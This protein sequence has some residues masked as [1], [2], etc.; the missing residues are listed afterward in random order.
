MAREQ[1][2]RRE[3]KA[4]HYVG[5]ISLRENRDGG[6][7]RTLDLSCA[8]AV[9]ADTLRLATDV[10]AAAFAAEPAVAA[11]FDVVAAVAVGEAVVGVGDV[12][13]LSEVTIA[14]GEISH[15]S[16]REEDED[17][18]RIVVA[19]ASFAD[20]AKD[21]EERRELAEHDTELAEDAAV[22]QPA[23]ARRSFSFEPLQQPKFLRQYLFRSLESLSTHLF[24]LV[25]TFW[26]S[27]RQSDRS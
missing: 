17:E 3:R 9:A 21:A 4:I 14:T 24:V 12:A 5:S 11:S 2:S 1:K 15:D 6:K 13:E 26:I 10:P 19:I 20:L 27:S 8:S 7:R 25:E 18:R 23:V 22:L 16:M